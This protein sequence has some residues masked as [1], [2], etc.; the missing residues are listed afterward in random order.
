MFLSRISFLVQI[1]NEFG[2]Q[3]VSVFIAN[4]IIKVIC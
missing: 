1:I 2:L 3:N 4:V